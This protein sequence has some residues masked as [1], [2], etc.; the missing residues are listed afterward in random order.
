MNIFVSN[1]GFNFYTEELV[2]LF[3]E[4][5]VITGASVATDRYT[6]K[7]KGYGFVEMLNRDEG[8]DAISKLNGMVIDGRSISV[9]EAKPPKRPTF[10]PR[11]Y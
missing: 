5:G 6:G 7:S 1:L 2:N 11:R 3:I 10:T 8:E 4:Y 9:A